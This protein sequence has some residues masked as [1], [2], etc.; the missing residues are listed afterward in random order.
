MAFFFEINIWNFVYA[1]NKYKS[2]YLI[3]FL[4]LLSNLDEDMQPSWTASSW[5]LSTT[6]KIIIRVFI[7][8]LIVTEKQTWERELEET[9]NKEATVDLDVGFKI[10]EPA[11]AR[12]YGGRKW[13]GGLVIQ[14]TA[15]IFLFSSATSDF[16]S[17]S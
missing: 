4:I 16:E 5:P 13:L 11:V 12:N 1:E 3:P 6:K 15:S 8:I 7:D 9:R 17:N 10:G 14:C 2:P